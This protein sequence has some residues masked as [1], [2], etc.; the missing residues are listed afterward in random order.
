MND[1]L[2]LKYYILLGSLTIFLIWIYMLYKSIQSIKKLKDA[3][4]RSFLS[5]LS[6]TSL[7]DL[8][9]ARKTNKELDF[10]HSNYIQNVRRNFFIWI[11]SLLTFVITT[12]IIGVLTTKR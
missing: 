10:A 5:L 7:K 8:N 9:R 12:I 2:I 6:L 1:S 3:T 11:F 4:G